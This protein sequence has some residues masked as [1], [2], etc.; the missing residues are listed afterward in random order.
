MYFVLG[1][2][3]VIISKLLIRGLHGIYNYDVS[4]ND[5]LTFIFGEN[6][7]GKTT[8]LNIVSAVVTGK[9]YNLFDY[10]FDE[11]VLYY[12]NR[13]A[14]RKKE[15]S[16][17]I[18]SMENRYKITLESPKIE[19]LIHDVRAFREYDR[20]DEYSLERRFFS[21]YES[22][23]YLKKAFNY[24]YLPLSRNSQNGINAFDAMPTRRK[25]APRYSERDLIN[26]NYLNDSLRYIEELVRDGFMRIS[27]AENA[28]N[29][30]FR[31]DLLASSLD[32]TSNYD[33]SSLTVGGS[34]PPSLAEIENKRKEYVK[35]LKSLGEWNDD[36]NSRVDSF[37]SKYKGAY[38]DMQDMG[39][40]K[41]SD[42]LTTAALAM[43]YLLMTLGFYRIT[44][45]AAQAQAVEEEK[46]TVRSPMDAFLTTVN[47]F[48]S[49]SEDKKHIEIN[50]DGRIVVTADSPRRSVSLYHLSSGEKQIIIIF[51][52]LIFGLTTNKNGIYI[53]DEPEAS[54]HLAW[55]RM[56]VKSIRNVNSSIQLIFATHAPE[57]IGRDSDHAVKLKKHV[58]P[59]KLE[60]VGLTDE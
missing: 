4:F 48:L 51:A 40:A 34:N 6:G 29:L 16:V 19:E 57:I 59:E 20:E 43:N 14:K 50:A 47:K 39:N 46:E 28:I 35:I 42:S 27:T 58:D 26:K 37:F 23:N 56:F 32:V 36:M 7:C 38:K 1:E 41:K 2:T 24:I 45:I 5:D 33:V 55:Q 44:Q 60:K 15:E 10:H 53:I 30:K 21:E 12:R 22:P 25:Y 54:L 13:S 49:V 11:I 3:D 17:R 18:V 9:L 52:Y 8:I 31:K